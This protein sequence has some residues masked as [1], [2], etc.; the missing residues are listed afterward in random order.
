LPVDV[1]ALVA[2]ELEL[3]DAGERHVRVGRE[4]LVDGVQVDPK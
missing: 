2:G 4:R 3:L 1:P